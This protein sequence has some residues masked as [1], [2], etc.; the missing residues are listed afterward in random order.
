MKAPVHRCVHSLL[1][2]VGTKPSPSPCRHPTCW[3]YFTAVPHTKYVSLWSLAFK[4]KQLKRVQYGDDIKTIHIES[5]WPL[6]HTQ[7]RT[8]TVKGQKRGSL[9]LKNQNITVVMYCE[10]SSP[11]LPRLWTYLFLYAVSVSFSGFKTKLQ[12][13][14]AFFGCRAAL[15]FNQLDLNLDLRRGSFINVYDAMVT[16]MVVTH[17]PVSHCD[18]QMLYSHG[19][20]SA[21]QQ[22]RPNPDQTL[23]FLC[24][25]FILFFLTLDFEQ[26]NLFHF[27]KV[28]LRAVWRRSTYVKATVTFIKSL[29]WEVSSSAPSLTICFLSGRLSSEGESMFSLLTNHWQKGWHTS[30]SILTFPV[31]V[32]LRVSISSAPLPASLSMQWRQCVIKAWERHRRLL[33]MEDIL[34]WYNQQRQSCQGTL[35]SSAFVQEANA[36]KQQILTVHICS[37]M[38]LSCYPNLGHCGNPVPS[39]KGSVCPCQ[40]HCECQTDAAHDEYGSVYSL[41]KVWAALYGLELKNTSKQ[42]WKSS[43]ESFFTCTLKLGG[44]VT[45]SVLT[46]PWR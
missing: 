15:W 7:K 44:E 31:S 46:E 12:Y 20:L 18:P 36:L 11:E 9:R 6:P 37:F 45:P 3:I 13:W 21:L 42:V 28:A 33:H 41:K 14:I 22:Q 39:Q 10:H 35:L 5:L 25:F 2:D 1:C 23:C 4:I 24:A 8:F 16:N 40:A 38:L 26:P 43:W 30:S 27:T 29:K 34:V 32:F 17:F 19:G